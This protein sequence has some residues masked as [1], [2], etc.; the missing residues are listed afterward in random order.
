MNKL[1][2]LPAVLVFGL[3][4]GLAC[5]GPSPTVQAHATGV[6]QQATSNCSSVDTSRLDLEHQDLL[7][8]EC[9][10]P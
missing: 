6:Q 5:G 1:L 3:V 10:A 4:F 8:F 7:R 2:W 9:P